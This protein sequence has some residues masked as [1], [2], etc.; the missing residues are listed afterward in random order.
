MQSVL[1]NYRSGIATLGLGNLGSLHII[2]KALVVWFSDPE[3]LRG[4]GTEGC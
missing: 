3:S 4:I 1:R 2:F